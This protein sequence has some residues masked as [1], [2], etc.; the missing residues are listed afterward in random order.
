MSI[1][2]SKSPKTLT[3]I[4]RALIIGAVMGGAGWFVGKAVADATGGGDLNL[5]WSDVLAAIVALG[6][7]VSAVAVLITS[8]DPVRLS[9][10]YGQEEASTPAEVAQARGQSLLIGFSGLLMVLPLALERLAAPA[11]PAMAGVLVLLALHTVMNIRAYLRLDELYRRAVQEQVMATFLL[12]QGLLFVWAV[13]ERLV[14]L[15]AL[16]AWDIYVLLMT[17]YLAASTV[18]SVRRGLA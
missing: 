18:V 9:K 12:G 10:M 2:S 5:T 13:G 6:L 16:A 7:F 17:F 14:G 3:R 8:L 4:L 1:L 11:A 15:P